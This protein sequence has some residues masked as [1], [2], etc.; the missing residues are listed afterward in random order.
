MSRPLICIVGRSGAGKNYIAHRLEMLGY[1]SVRSYT[2]RAIRAN[3]P[4]DKDTHI[5]ITPDRVE[6][7]KD[8]IVA[9]TTFNG[10]FYFSTRKQMNE[11]DI[12][13]LDI[14]GLRELRQTYKDKDIV[15]IFLDCNDEILK[16]RM[17]KR[18]DS[19]QA[20][21]DRIQNDAIMFRDAKKECGFVYLNE[22]N[23]QALDIVKFIDMF[24]KGYNG[25]TKIGDTNED[26]SNCDCNCSFGD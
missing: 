9:S 19:E 13:I 7:Y 17:T 18:G 25:K 12:Y 11:N 21:A 6:D 1:S 8:D 2:T 4:K 24:I 23:E 3:D 5:F 26:N 22:T 16:E 20:I 15:S 10:N 14:A